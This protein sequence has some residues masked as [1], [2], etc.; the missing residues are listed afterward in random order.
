M[1]LI[2][3]FAI[4]A[5]VFLSKTYPQNAGV[6]FYYLVFR[7]KLDYRMKAKFE[8]I[9]LTV[10]R[11]LPILEIGLPYIRRFIKPDKI[12]IIASKPCLKKINN[13]GFVSEDIVLLDEDSVVEGVTLDYVRSLVESRGGEA[14]RAGWYFKQLLNFAYA[15]RAETMDYYLTW[16]IDTIPV[17]PISFFDK[18]GRM[19]LARKS[20]YHKPYFHTI[21]ALIGL[22][23]EV[24]FSFIAE[25][26]V[27]KRDYMLGL[28]RLIVRGENLEGRVFVK[29]VIDAI[30]VDHISG[31]G[32]AE[33][34][35]YGTYVYKKFPEAVLVRD[36]SSVRWGADLCGLNPSVSDLYTLSTRYS[37]A[38]FESW[39]VNTIAQL[40]RRV[41]LR[42]LGRIWKFGV[43]VTNYKA[44]SS[45]K[46]GN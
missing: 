17:R 23:R 29:N 9:L 41:L 45:F 21:E 20:E 28:L 32:F 3:A 35:T 27:F 36:I 13:I 37:W 8:L 1:Y 7:L 25:H 24:G 31:S 4:K 46:S 40:G 5:R 34:E 22:K 16:D 43:V 19:L 2:L 39:K 10:E 14:W 6:E 44:Y 26:M 12:T 30:Q 15:M 18:R 38:S 42:V 33:Y 11:H